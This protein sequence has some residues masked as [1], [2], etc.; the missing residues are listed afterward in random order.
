MLGLYMLILG[1]VSF[2]TLIVCLAIKFD[3]GADVICDDD[4]GVILID[5]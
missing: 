4:L 1:T 5:C 2:G 3:D